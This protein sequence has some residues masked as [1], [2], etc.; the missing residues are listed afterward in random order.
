MKRATKSVD[1]PRASARLEALGA[2]DTKTHQVLVQSLP[3]LEKYWAD[4]SGCSSVIETIVQLASEAPEAAEALTNRLSFEPALVSDP[5]MFRRWVSHG[6]RMNGVHAKRRLAHFQLGDPNT[7]R[8]HDEGS[9]AAQIVLCGPSLVHYMNGFGCNVQQIELLD[10]SL[11]TSSQRA[12]LVDRVT[13]Q[14]PH[15]DMSGTRGERELRYRATAAHIAAHLRYSPLGRESG[16][17]RPMLLALMGLLEDSRVERLMLRDCPG[18]QDIWGSFHTASRVTSGFQFPGLAARLSHALHNPGYEDKNDWVTKARHA[19]EEIAARDLH[20][21][22]AF[23]RLARELSI[24]MGRMRQAIPQMYQMEPVYRD[25]NSALWSMPSL[26]PIDESIVPEIELVETT[27]REAIQSIDDLN[28]VDLRRRKFYPEW[29]HRLEQLKKDWTTVIESPTPLSQATSNTTPKVAATRHQVR[30]LERT[31]DRAI[32]LNRQPEGDELD[33][34]SVIESTVNLRLNM[35]PDE[36]VF[37]RHGRRRRTTAVV[38]LMDLSVSTQRYVPGSFTKVLDVEK[39]A[40]SVVAQAL[41]Q[42]HDRV[43]IHGF[44]SNGRHEVNYFRIKDF[45]DSFDEIRQNALRT[46]T[47]EQSTRMGAALRHASEALH[48]ETADQKVILMLTDGEPSDIDVLEDDYLIEDARNAVTTASGKGIRTFC[49]TLDRRADA[50][51][52]RIFGS[53]NYLI[54][55][56]AESF[57]GWAGQTLVKLAA[58]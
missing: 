20:D 36:R 9:E 32:R 24:Q 11:M 4:D 13:V 43:A 26:A 42:R 25:D 19:F 46:L 56:R 48:Q 18:L 31:P 15:G 51:V 22:A 21:V 29:D 3:L 39:R 38:L 47:G 27:S 23:D 57:A 58:H 37:R 6:L 44:C 40:A 52:S 34:N 41:D 12:K 14:L 54:A 2:V 17:R 50:Y 49:L 55:E 35:A 10:G 16:N 28:E 45:D 7:F 53:R 30:G 33:L 8:E 1:C 5:N